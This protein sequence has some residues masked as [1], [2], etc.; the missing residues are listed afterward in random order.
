M[1]SS[2]THVSSI[3][4]K[5]LAG[6]LE[7]DAPEVDLEI[8]GV[9]TIEDA[10]PTDMTFLANDAYVQA[11]QDSKAGAVLVETGYEGEAPMPM[12]RSARPRLAFA[13]L[14]EM[15]HP[16]EH[17]SATVHPSA[18]VPDS[19][20]IGTDVAIGAYAVLGENVRVGDRTRIHAHAVIYDDAV[21]GADCEVHSHAVV[22]EAVIVGDRVALQNGAIIGAD[23]FGFEPD[24]SGNF[25][26]VPQ[27]GSVRIGDDVDIQANACVDRSAVGAT[28][29]GNGTKIDNLTQ[30]AH[31]CTV[32]EN[33]VLCGQ[34]GLAG[35]THVGNRV[36]LGGQVG[37]AGHIRFHDD[38]QVAAQSGVM[39][40]CESGKSYGG[41][42]AMELKDALRSALYLPR[43]PEMARQIKKN[44]RALAKLLD[45]DG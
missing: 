18:I 1:Q 34:V 27:V 31:G 45:A 22:R 19:C 10:G 17:R 8:T 37:S 7:I 41:T 3:T 33:S 13:R 14:L 40:D 21:L 36:M 12:L 2:T 24:E 15:F 28:R 4:L 20:S 25:V 43:L 9:A 6:R 26:K 29:I 30:V 23:G 38:S 42:P 35:S 32:G 5:D 16:V 39:Q 44:T 11:L